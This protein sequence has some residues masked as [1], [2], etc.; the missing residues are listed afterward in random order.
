MADFLISREIGIDAAHRV[1][2]HGSKCKNLHGHRYTIHAACT[3]L[4][5]KGGEESGMVID[6]GFLKEE[7]MA[8]IDKYCDHALI[9]GRD[10]PYLADLVPQW[11]I[12]HSIQQS[13]DADSWTSFV[14][15]SVDRPL[16]LYI[17]HDA[18]TAEV[19]AAHWFERLSSRVLARTNNRARLSYVRVWETPNCWAQ[20]PTPPANGA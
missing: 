15:D 1:P 13:L 6:F 14:R 9:L 12:Q 3:G 2:H 4:L 5:A 16:K 11:E 17:I 10:D 8:I 19:L 20:Y 18:P 7:M